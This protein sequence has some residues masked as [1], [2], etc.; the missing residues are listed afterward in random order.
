LCTDFVWLSAFYVGSADNTVMMRRLAALAA[1]PVLALSL[2]AAPAMAAPNDAP[3]APLSEPRA[4][5]VCTDY[6]NVS[7][8]L[9]GLID[10][11]I[12]LTHHWHGHWCGWVGYPI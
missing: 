4:M 11:E 6:P 7:L 12:D 2:A 10:L 8:D 5:W 9:L 3:P 1:L